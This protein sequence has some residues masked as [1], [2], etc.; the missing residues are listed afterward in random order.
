MCRRHRFNVFNAS[1]IF[2][3]R[4]GEFRRAPGYSYYVWPNQPS[5]PSWTTLEGGTASLRITR[6]GSSWTSQTEN[7]PMEKDTKSPTTQNPKG[8]RTI[9]GTADPKKKT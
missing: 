9:K 5:A 8:T 2:C 1:L 7:I 4:C 3:T 6:N